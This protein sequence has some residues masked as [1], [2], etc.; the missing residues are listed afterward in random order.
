MPEIL[1]T[2][3]ESAPESRFIGI[4][5]GEGDREGGGFAAKWSEWFQKDRFNILEGLADTSWQAQFPEAE[6][7]IGLMRLGEECFEYWIGLFLPPL[8][9]VPQGYESMDFEAQD[10]GVCFV[11][12]KE[13]DI[14]MQ[15]EACQ[16]RLKSEGFVPYEDESGAMWVMERYQSPRFT[17][18]DGEGQRILDLVFPVLPDAEDALEM[19]GKRYCGS[20][21]AAFAG[22]K[23]PE[24]GN[25]GTALQADDPILIGELPGPLRNAMQI[26][27]QA[28]EIPFTALP[29]KGLG[30]TMSAGDILETY[31]VYVPFERSEEAR[32][33]LLS[34]LSDWRDDGAKNE[35][36][37]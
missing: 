23:C 28:T 4:K 34:V 2:R 10:L 6:S 22:E 19:E 32:E 12:G 30:F 36:E 35:E 7:R 27:F 5:Y 29:T 15:E 17:D 1:S 11:K 20:C 16:K 14:F 24:C 3:R 13:P 37:E 8:T 21:Y 9:P 25:S 33:A 31:M 26:T 18:P